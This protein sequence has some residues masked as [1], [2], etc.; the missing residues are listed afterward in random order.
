[1]SPWGE[2]L[3]GLV[4]LAGLVGTII[5][6]IPGSFLVLGAVLVWAIV[7]GGQVAW[8]VFAI[9]A[10]VV[11]IAAV[12]KFVVAGKYMVSKDIP[13]STMW[14]GGAA[15]VVGFFVIP[16][17]G[18]LIGFVAGVWVAELVR[19][20]DGRAAW[21]ATV[22][23]LKATGI[24]ILVELAAGLIATTAWIVGLVQT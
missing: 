11:L 5:Q 13:S 9:S 6:I 22:V 14:W 8:T 16:V 20:K 23:A 15:G 19:R 1:M 3:V 4:I 2:V 12:V 24:S 10:V 18:L 7:T 17:V 21:E